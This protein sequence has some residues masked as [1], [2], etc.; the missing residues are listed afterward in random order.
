MTTIAQ[1][2]FIAVANKRTYPARHLV[3]EAGAVPNSLFLVIAGSVSVLVQD[4]DGRE[5]VLAYL[6]PGEFFGEMGLFPAQQV[7]TA[8]VRTRTQSLIAEVGY[9]EFRALAREQPDLMFELAGQLASRLRDTSGRLRDLT[10]VDAAG[11]LA[12]VLMTMLDGP[13]AR[14]HPRGT[15]IPVNRQELSR[16]IGCSREMAGRII[17]RFHDD[18]LIQANGR[19]LVVLAS[20]RLAKPR[21]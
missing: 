12:R 15:L 13:D 5:M 4:D 10:F 17:K 19:S 2:A 3:I 11:R 18:G 9:T 1:Q 7:R 6:S 21:G 14:P 16:L 8:A 20:G